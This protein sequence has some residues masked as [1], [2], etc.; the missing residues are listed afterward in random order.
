MYYM[1]CTCTLPHT[2]TQTNNKNMTHT[3]TYLSGLHSGMLS[4]GVTVRQMDSLSMLDGHKQMQR[5]NKAK[6][7]I[8]S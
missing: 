7:I 2:D 1:N 4:V 8:S 5:K 3:V 6:Q